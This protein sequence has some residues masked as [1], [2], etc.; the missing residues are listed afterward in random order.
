MFMVSAAGVVP[1]AGAR[2]L[3]NFMLEANYIQSRILHFY[4]RAAL[5]YVKS[6]GK[7]P[8]SLRWQ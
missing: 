5:D 2:L 4:L 1:P 8:W 6:P 3:R 7:A